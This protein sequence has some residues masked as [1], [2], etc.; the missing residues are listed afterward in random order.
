MYDRTVVRKSF[1]TEILKYPVPGAQNPDASVSIHKS[2]TT[3][4][5]KAGLEIEI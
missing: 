2:I 1:G 5:Y 3:S 4:R